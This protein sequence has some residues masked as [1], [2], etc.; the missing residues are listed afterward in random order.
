M[1][2]RAV[3]STFNGMICPR[4]AKFGYVHGTSPAR[5][6]FTFDGQVDLPVGSTI[7]V[8]IGSSYFVGSVILVEHENNTNE[9]VTTKVKADDFRDKL[10]DNYV[11]AAFNVKESDGRIWHLFPDDWYLDRK[12]W[13]S[14]ELE[15]QD[16][17]N[18]QNLAANQ[19]QNPQQ[20]INLL[21]NHAKQNLI[22]AASILNFLASTFSFRW[23]C[24][25]NVRTI[26]KKNYPFNLNWS[27]GEKG[28]N[29][30]DELLKKLGLQFTWFG[31]DYMYITM[32]GWSHNSFINAFN[33]GFADICNAG[34]DS[35]S[36]GKEL[37]DKGRRVIIVGDRNSYQHTAMLAANWNP[38]WTWEL[39]YG[40][41]Q[42]SALLRANGL[43]MLSKVKEL[44][45]KYHDEE[46]WIGSN[47]ISFEGQAPNKRTRNEMTIQEYIDQIA[48][49]VYV[50]DIETLVNNFT[51][52]QKNF[53]GNWSWFDYE[54]FR[55]VDPPVGNQAIGVPPAQ[56]NPATFD[57][58]NYAAFND[59]VNSPVPVSQ[60]LVTETNARFVVWGTTRKIIDGK[61][62]PVEDQHHLVP[63]QEGVSM[64]IENIINPKTAQEEY[65]IRF[66]FSAPQYRINKDVSF[67]DPKAIQP[68]IVLA[69]LAFDREIFGYWKGEQAAQSVRVRTQKKDISG[70]KKSFIYGK[71][72]NGL[73]AE[74]HIL[75][76]KKGGAQPAVQPVK[77]IDIADKIANQLL[78]HMAVN[79]TGYL[80]FSHSAGFLPDGII[81]TVS[82]NFSDE[83]GIS[84]TVNFASGWIDGEIDNPF[85]LNRSIPLQFANQIARQRL[86]D[87]AKQF[88]AGGGG[89]G[90][91]AGGGAGGAG[92][93]GN[94]NT[95]GLF[96]R[97]GGV[98]SPESSYSMYGGGPSAPGAV[99]IKIGKAELSDMDADGDVDVFDLMILGKKVVVGDE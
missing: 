38:A 8:Q 44:P 33:S 5:A 19:Q 88:N 99:K 35:G 71:E 6:D 84:E 64:D 79:E 27:G 54:N 43:T 15:Q 17:N 65:R 67:T 59:V 95:G 22:S 37:N 83:T 92:N 46:T 77:A 93:G 53:Q 9:G 87:M 42:L 21:K 72:I 7:S 2:S 13:V 49:H 24:D 90:G 28:A 16:M 85:V 47:D 39:C 82:V 18:L 97:R 32:R 26:L 29:A 10:H 50:L 78:F 66:V 98:D 20:V 80:S 3:A 55:S 75:N 73:L 68:D 12:T 62:K 69:T 74:N 25:S 86:I 34:A 4:Q 40:G 30:V 70:L 60:H 81:D 31:L 36:K 23:F 51:P 14:K 58:E 63:I 11:F 52:V 96:R 94:Q 56:G 45:E 57:I 41:W 48:F 76:L 61:S 1:A 91:N 89:Q